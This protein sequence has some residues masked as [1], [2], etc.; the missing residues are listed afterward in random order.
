[1]NT[2]TTAAAATDHMAELV[3]ALEKAGRLRGAAAQAYLRLVAL[4]EC[5]EYRELHERLRLDAEHFF[6]TTV[7]QCWWDIQDVVEFCEG[8]VECD[9]DDFIDNFEDVLWREQ[10]CR[11][12]MEHRCLQSEEMVKSLKQMLVESDRILQEYPDAPPQIR[13]SLE[14]P[15]ADCVHALLET[16]EEMRDF[17]GN[18]ASTMKGIAHLSESHKPQDVL[19]NWIPTATWL[20]DAC[21]SYGQVFGIEEESD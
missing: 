18:V 2:S 15:F 1:M 8:Y 19:F 10:E 4:P 9:E 12:G 16:V 5:E 3:A 6:E 20:A 13:H 7:P 17:F 21:R 14:G 11:A